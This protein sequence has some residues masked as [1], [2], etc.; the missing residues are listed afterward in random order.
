MCAFGAVRRCGIGTPPAPAWRRMTRANCPALRSPCWGWRGAQIAPRKFSARRS[1]NPAAPQGEKGGEMKEI[2]KT[3]KTEI[4]DRLNEILGRSE[5]L[6]L[7]NA[8]T[9]EEMQQ[10]RE[11]IEALRKIIIKD[12]FLL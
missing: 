7:K 6:E 3:R 4:N 10:I 1:R 12:E 8:L 2:I 11:H 5:E 9:R